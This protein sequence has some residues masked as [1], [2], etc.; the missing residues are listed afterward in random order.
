MPTHHGGPDGQGVPRWDF[1]T[2]ANA[3]GPAPRVLRAV[4]AA[5]VTRYP[6]PSYTTLRSA[7]AT[8]HGVEAHRIV[9]A[10]SASEFIQR[11]THAVALHAPHS[12]VHAPHPGYAD[13]ARAAQACGWPRRAAG[14][15]RLVWHTEPSSPCGTS[16][17]A[18][19]VRDDAV[20]VID[21]AYE[22][23]RLEGPAPPLPA[24]AWRLMSPNKALGLTGVRGAYAIAPPE[25]KSE[26]EPWREALHR[27]TPSW[28][29]GAHGVAMLMAWAQ[30]DTQAWV[31]SCHPRLRDWKHQQIDRLT[32]LGWVCEPSVTNFFVARCPR[33]DAVEHLRCHGI[34]LRDTTNMGLPG[35]LRLSVQAPEA[36]AALVAAWHQF[37]VKN[38][39]L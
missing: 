24:H 35:A 18:P 6:D 11:L 19:A 27:L 28:P 8:L 13:Y 5:D 39:S 2:N 22:P 14:D 21:M 31:Q 10:A 1:S 12:G 15:A 9:I 3:C 30:D 25:S 23:L 33:P 34:K 37:P 20:L 29:L 38:T 4:Q 16:A 26:P 36:Q 7:L 17:R 32:A